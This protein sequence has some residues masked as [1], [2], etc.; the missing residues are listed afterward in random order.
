VKNNHVLARTDYLPK[1]EFCIYGW[2][3]K[4]K[5]YAKETRFSVWNY[6]KPH[7]NDLHPTMK[8]IELIMQNITDSTEEGMNVF[9]SFSGSGTT[10]IACEKTNRNC[11]TIEI[12]PVYIQIAIDRWEK[13]TNKE[14]IKIKQ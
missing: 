10:L 7:I 3:G 11:Y 13:L 8:P 5:F 6:D 14:A 1:H 4:H 2:K 12:D 9:D